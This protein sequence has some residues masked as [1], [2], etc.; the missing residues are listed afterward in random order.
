MPA[1]SSRS[2]LAGAILIVAA[3]TATAAAAAPVV[4]P[5]IAA[6]PAAVVPLIEGVDAG[7]VAVPATGQTLYVVDEAGGGVIG[8]DPT[9]P[10]KRW[11]AV[12]AASDRGARPVAIGCIDTSHLAAVRRVGGE[13]LLETFRLPAPA[14]TSAVEKP[15]SSTPL[16][17][18]P[19]ADRP[20]VTVG[21][22]RDWLAITGLTAPLPQAMAFRIRGAKPAQEIVR[23]PPEGRRAVASATTPDDAL[24]LLTTDPSRPAGPARL[25]IRQPSDPRPLIDLDLGL[26]GLRA[27]ACGRGDGTLWVLGG[28]AGSASMPTGL[29]RIDAV[30]RDGR[31]AARAVCVTRID[32]PRGLAWVSPRMILVSHGETA[33]RVV[34]VDPT[35]ARIDEEGNR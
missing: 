28:E 21:F 31:Q 14:A 16:G 13:W 11:V 19:S 17:P 26:S 22:S 12:A 32:A 30:M 24:V 1:R 9:Q 18:A 10:Q 35:T 33:G 27:A 8:C 15:E 25:S 3:W 5:V 29:W 7:A 2:R 20:A 4:E 6:V 23:G 34:H